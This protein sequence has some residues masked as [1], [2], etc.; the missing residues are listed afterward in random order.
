VQVEE[1][2]SALFVLLSSQVYGS[3]RIPFPHIAMVDI[4]S[5]PFGA[6]AVLQ[7]QVPFVT[8]K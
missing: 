2:P 4:H 3:S 6:N 5:D 1:H 8:M 7:E